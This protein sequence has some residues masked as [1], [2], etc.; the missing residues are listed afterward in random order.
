M[1][2][3][4][5]TESLADLRRK[6]KAEI[7]AKIEE[8]RQPGGLLETINHVSYGDRATVEMV[9][10]MPSLWVLPLPHVPEIRGGH[11]ALHDF[12]FD[13]IVMTYSL[14][15]QAG[16]E[17]AEDL[18]AT[19]YDV[20]NSMR[21]SSA[22]SFFDVRPQSIDPSFEAAAGSAVYWSSCEFAFRIQRRE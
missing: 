17:Q 18:A 14:D 15:E 8:A 20:L 7:L 21:R 3:Q 6:I 1:S 16:R 22:D 10:N 12:I 5:N 9:D 13:F 2:Y 4:I 11:T 19:I